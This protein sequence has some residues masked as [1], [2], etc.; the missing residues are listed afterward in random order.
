MRVKRSR[1][2]RTNT[3][4]TLNQTHLT[5]V[6]VNVWG[7][8]AYGFGVRVFL[9]GPNFDAAK[10]EECL[11]QNFVQAYPQLSGRI[12]C[13]DNASFHAT[14]DL[15]R[16]FARHQMKVLKLAPQSSDI[17]IIENIWGLADRQLSHH[18]LTNY[19]N[20]PADLFVKVKELCEGIP[21][22]MVN[23]LFDTIPK[24]IKEVREKRGKATHY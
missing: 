20:R 7:F 6:A 14:P 22:E 4:F 15:K 18:L 3:E 2:E 11:A 24:R 12:F 21:V 19:I 17:N 13:Q 8:V 23:S 10:Y 5:S 1:G 16:F 9:A